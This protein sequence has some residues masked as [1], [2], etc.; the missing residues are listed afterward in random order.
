MFNFLKKKLSAIH[1]MS[2]HNENEEMENTIEQPPIIEEQSTVDEPLIEDRE[3]VIPQP[4]RSAR[5]AARQELKRKLIVEEGQREEQR[6]KRFRAEQMARV[7][8][9]VAHGK[10]CVCLKVNNELH[11]LFD[12]EIK[13]PQNGL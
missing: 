3:I 8:Q 11:W 5:I 12:I 1:I 7:M 2:F 6:K 13:N 10:P 9:K 4:R